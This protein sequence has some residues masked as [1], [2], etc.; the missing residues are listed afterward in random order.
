[1]PI[2]SCL[3]LN[4]PV[5]EPN[6]QEVVLEEKWLRDTMFYDYFLEQLS[7]R[8]DPMMEQE[9]QQKLVDLDKSAL[10]AVHAVIKQDKPARALDLCSKSFVIP[11]VHFCS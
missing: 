4:I 10:P 6:R 11:A 2:V 9:L 3:K 1:M 7:I 5:L 8:Y